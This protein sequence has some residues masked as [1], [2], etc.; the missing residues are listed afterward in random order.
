MTVK[1]ITVL[2]NAARDGDSSAM[3]LVYNAAY[4]ELKKLA[5]SHRR[6]WRGNNTMNATALISE[7]F[8]KLAGDGEPDFASRTHFFATASRAMRQVLVNYAQQQN[9]AKRGGGAVRITLDEEKLTG[10]TTVDELLSLHEMLT[11]LEAD[12][13][14]RCQIVECRVFGG[15]TVEE[16]AEALSISP[17]TVKR[18]WQ[19]ASARIYLALERN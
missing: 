2:L 10:D 17:A 5:L 19:V 12:N 1:P 11:R 3:D 9:A 16:V 7:V 14:R 6:R 18:E 4:E 8:I 15:M 13:P